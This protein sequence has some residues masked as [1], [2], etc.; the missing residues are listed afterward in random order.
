MYVRA[1]QISRSKA[2]PILPRSAF[3]MVL[4][5]G[6]LASALA[7]FWNGPTF[8]QTGPMYFEQVK[9][10]G[11]LLNTQNDPSQPTLIGKG[12]PRTLAYASNV[13]ATDPNQLATRTDYALP[14]STQN[15]TVTTGVNTLAIQL[16]PWRLAIPNYQGRYR[17][18]YR[19]YLGVNSNE[20]PVVFTVDADTTHFGIIGFETGAACQL[21]GTTTRIN[22][23]QPGETR[24]AYEFGLTPACSQSNGTANLPLY[25]VFDAGW[26]LNTVGI[27]QAVANLSQ[28]KQG[29]GNYEI[30]ESVAR[31]LAAPAVP[32]T[33]SASDLPAPLAP[34]TVGVRKPTRMALGNPLYTTLTA[35]AGTD[36]VIGSVKV[37]TST[38]LDVP[39]LFTFEPAAG[40][41]G[42]GSI[43]V[44]FSSLGRNG[45]VPITLTGV[46]AT[47]T[48]NALNDT[49]RLLSPSV[50]GYTVTQRS[51]TSISLQ[52]PA[53]GANAAN[54]SLTPVAA[55][56]LPQRG[57]LGPQLITATVTVTAPQTLGITPLSASS[58][59]ETIYN[60]GV[61]FRVPW[62][63]GSLA[64]NPGL[65][66]LAN[67]TTTPA[68]TIYVGLRAVTPST[69]SIDKTCTPAAGIPIGSEF[70]FGSGESAQ[71]FGD[72]R[73]GDLI[74]AVS[75]QSSALIAKARVLSNGNYITEST[76]E[77]LAADGTTI[78]SLTW[79]G[80]A[81]ATTPSIMRI[82][83]ASDTPSGPVSLSLR[84]IINGSQPGPISC[85]SET[86]P[87]LSSIP[88]QGELVMTS[89]EATACFGVFRRGDLTV[90]ISGS[91]KGL[92][93]RMRVISGAGLAVAE[94]TLGALPVDQTANADNLNPIEFKAGWYGGPLAATPS[95]LRLSNSAAV[96]AG[97]IVLTLD[98]IVGGSSSGPLTC[99]STKLS[100]LTAIAPGGELL[101]DPPAA[102]RP[103]L[104][105][106]LSKG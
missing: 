56:V 85:T 95:I 63:G 11:L 54:I 72:F 6:L 86:L 70:L 35:A 87:Q 97:P 10:S 24:V 19:L 32:F 100:S 79:F 28:D 51:A 57:I 82:S 59:L 9:V 106:Q 48:L 23:G 13:S 60:E 67:D 8:A 17:I 5:L 14:T 36:A 105:R 15:G 27:V 43:P 65:I 78:G 52:G 42:Y 89:S 41:E 88:A 71:C 29:T 96:S 64:A 58:T 34:A 30:T 26:K 103:G 1:N 94:Q 53:T 75:A 38:D 99:D 2:K 44:V 81:L 69:V 77:P 92:S 46:S 49:W 16:F 22:G 68:R 66:R 83:N 25:L 84:N 90:T 62:F 31:P 20:G 102:R 3:A 104:L 12:S 74:V 40:R 33:F 7:A 47:V 18:E 98:N 61:A 55:P 21:S 73:R 76:L 50:P 39:S 101:V 80:G 4:R 37:T 45:L 93:T 91:T